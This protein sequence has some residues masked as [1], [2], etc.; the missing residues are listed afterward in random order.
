[1]KRFS[2]YVALVVAVMLSG[3]GVKMNGEHS[4]TL[5]SNVMLSAAQS[6]QAEAG[7][8]S[9]AAMTEIVRANP[10]KWQVFK[11]AR[12]PWMGFSKVYLNAGYTRLL[13]KTLAWSK[14][15]ARRSVAGELETDDLV[16]VLQITKWHWQ[17]FADA[18][19]GIAPEEE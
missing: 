10:P 5:D 15:M 7:T 8:L 11:D 3:C 2:L 13:D 16:W 6:D 17:D 1:M 14:D 18:R 19:D 12:G 4:A 9:D